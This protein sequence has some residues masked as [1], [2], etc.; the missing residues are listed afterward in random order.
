M[1]QFD[2]YLNSLAVSTENYENPALS[3][4]YDDLTL[5]ESYDATEIENY[6]KQAKRVN[7]STARTMSTK[8]VKNPRARM[9]VKEAMRR[10]GFAAGFRPSGISGG[11]APLAAQ[12]DIQITRAT[13]TIAQDL[14][15][16][17]FGAFDLASKY[18]SVITLPSGV[19][20]TNLE[21]GAIGRET[22]VDITYTSGANN[23]VVRITI[24]Q[25]EYPSFLNA[26]AT[27][28]FI[29]SN[30]KYSV[31]DT[32]ATGLQQLTKK[33]Q[34]VDRSMFG[35]LTQNDIPLASAK[36]PFQFQNGLVEIMGTFEVTAQTTWVLDFQNLANQQVTISANVAMADKG[37]AR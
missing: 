26:L 32:S 29:V 22:R 12:F 19:S 25:Y 3:G 14:P 15:V 33:F 20:I 4:N 37:L 18:R 5:E 24:P 6:L 17:I 31:S 30:A 28:R 7:P 13:A 36:S 27:S 10:D 21:V 35:R 1:N 16:P 34:S 9:E 2:Q 8:I 11:V 23:D